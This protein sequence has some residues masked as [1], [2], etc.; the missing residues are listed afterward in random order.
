MLGLPPMRYM[1]DDESVQHDRA[2]RPGE[3]GNPG[4]PGS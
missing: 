1:H 3:P 4:V 2:Y